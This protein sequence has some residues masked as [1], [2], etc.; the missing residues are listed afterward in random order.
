MYKMN[1]SLDKNFFK[2]LVIIYKALL[3]E[4][5]LFYAELFHE[6]G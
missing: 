1:M 4:F 5:A 2:K 3:K 6:K